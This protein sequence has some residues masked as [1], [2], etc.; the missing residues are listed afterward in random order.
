M[1]TVPGAW[2]TESRGVVGG[3]YIDEIPPSQASLQGTVFRNARTI[4]REDFSLR[5]YVNIARRKR[6]W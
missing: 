6:V 5:D 1:L 4:F 2:L 3:T